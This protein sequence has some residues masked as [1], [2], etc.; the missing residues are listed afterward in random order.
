MIEEVRTETKKK[1]KKKKM[2]S[3]CHSSKKHIREM[4]SIHSVLS[5]ENREKKEKEEKKVSRRFYS[6]LQSSYLLLPLF[7]RITNQIYDLIKAEEEEEKISSIMK[8]SS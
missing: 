1:K 6:H 4:V 5:F 8:K 3:M 2:I 7:T